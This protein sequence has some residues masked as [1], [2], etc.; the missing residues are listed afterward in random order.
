MHVARA[1]IRIIGM[2]ICRWGIIPERLWKG[3]GNINADEFRKDHI[4]YFNNPSNSFE[5]AAYYFELI[6]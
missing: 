6:N 3:E 1:K 2:E 5:F 4:A